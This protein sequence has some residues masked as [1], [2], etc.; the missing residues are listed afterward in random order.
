MEKVGA[1]KEDFL[2]DAFYPEVLDVQEGLKAAANMG[3]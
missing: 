3:I 1:G 2:V